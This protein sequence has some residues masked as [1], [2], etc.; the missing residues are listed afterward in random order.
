MNL[1]DG[2]AARFDQMNSAFTYLVNYDA[3]PHDRHLLLGYADWVQYVIEPV[4][5]Q[6]LRLLFQLASDRNTQMCWGDGGYIYAFIRDADL[7]ARRFS[8]VTTE[9]QC[10]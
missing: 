2:L 6:N 5:K 7:Q 3:G 4:R 8:Q 10:G 1:E 9:Y